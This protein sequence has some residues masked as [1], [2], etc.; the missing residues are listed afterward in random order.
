MGGKS[1]TSSQTVSIPPEVLARYNAVNSRAEQ[2][3]QKPFTSYSQDPSAFVAPLTS[4]QQAAVGN[5]NQLMG[6]Y[7]PDIST[8]QQ[9]MTAGASAAAPLV[10][11]GLGST[12]GAQQQAQG[13]YQGA[14]AGI[15][16]GTQAGQQATAQAQGYLPG[17]TQ[18]ITPMAFSQDAVQQY[19]S[20]YMSNVVAA[21]QAL[22]GQQNAQQRSQMTGDAI[23]AGAFGGDRA[24]IALAN[25]GQQQSLANQA[26]LSNLLQ[27]GYGQ[28][29]GAFQQQQGVDLSAQQANRAAQQ[30][31]A[32][33]QAA[34]GQ[35]Q[36]QQGLGA[37]Q[38]AA[39][40]GQGI[41]GMGSQT[42]AAQQQAGQN[43]FNIGQQYGQN[44]ANLGLS[45]YNAGLSGA[46]A[47]MGVG[48]VQQQTDQA[49]KSALYNQFLQQQGF[50]YQQ[51]QFLANIAEGTGSLSGSTTTTTQP[52][53]WSDKRLKDNVEK[54]GKTFDGQNIYAYNLKGDNERRL[55]LMAQE[56]EDKHPD[57][58]GLASGYKTV[59]YNKATSDAAKRGHFYS[60]G[61]VPNSEGGAVLPSMARQGFDDGGTAD[62]GD[63]NP[64]YQTL[65]SLYQS[66]LNRQA[67][68]AGL[69]YWEQQMAG[70]MTPRQ[71]QLAMDQS[72]EYQNLL[73]SQKA[74]TSGSPSTTGTTGTT[75]GSTAPA[76]YTKTI[77]D[78]YKS[79]FGRTPD[80]SG[81]QYYQNLMQQGWTADQV[82]SQLDASSEYKTAHP[83]STSTTGSTGTTD[84]S[85][86]MTLDQAKAYVGSLYSSDLNRSGD[87]S[88]VDYWAQQIADGTMSPSQVASSFAASNE[89]ALVNQT[90]LT[91]NPSSF[92]GQGLGVQPNRYGFY[93]APPTAYGSSFDPNSMI[94][95]MYGAY[96]GRTSDPSGYGYY[97]QQ[98]QSGSMSP[99]TIQSAF[100]NSAEAQGRQGYGGYQYPGAANYG[101]ASMSGYNPSSYGKG[102]QPSYSGSGY[103]A[104][105]TNYGT[106]GMP[107]ATGKGSSSYQP[108]TRY[109][110]TSGQYMPQ[111]SSGTATG[112]GPSSGS[113]SGSSSSGWNRG[114]R[115]GY[116]YGGAPDFSSLAAAQQQMYANLPGGQ[117]FE[118]IKLQPGSTRQLMT[119]TFKPQAPTSGINEAA[120]MGE[121]IAK[122]A[123][124][125][126]KAKQKLLGYTDENTG[127]KVPGLFG[128]SSE[129]AASSGQA[130]Q[131]GRPVS[132]LPG[133]TTTTT[134]KPAADLEPGLG[135]ASAPELQTAGL[136]PELTSDSDLLGGLGG[137][138]FA[139][140]GGRIGRKSGGPLNDDSSDD[141]P[142]GM[143]KTFGSG[144]NIPD[145]KGQYKLNV[146]Y[147]GSGSGS[148]SNPLGMISSGLGA[149]KAIG[150]I[151]G[152][153]MSLGAGA[154]A[155]A[156]G[157][158]GLAAAEGGGSFF[159]D[160][161][162][163]LFLARGGA[164][165]RRGYATDGGGGLNPRNPLTIDS[166]AEDVTPDDTVQLA[167]QQLAGA[168]TV[169]DDSGEHP[170]YAII[171]RGEG[172]IQK[173]KMDVDKLRIGYGSDTITKDDGTVLPVTKDTVISKE[174]A[175]RDLKRRV[176][177]FMGAAKKQVG[178]NI[179]NKLDPDSQGSLTSV[180]YN[181]GSLPSQ[182]V[183]A[184]KSGN[185]TALATAVNNLGGTN[186]GARAD[187]RAFEASLIDK[188]N[189]YAPVVSKQPAQPPSEAPSGGLAPQ[190]KF[191]TAVL[192]TQRPYASLAQ[193]AGL[194]LPEEL[195]QS[196]FW[197]PLLATVA[198]TM[199]S[200]RPKFGQALG[201]GIIGGLSAMSAQDQEQATLGLAGAKT[202]ETKQQADL[203]KAQTEGVSLQNFYKSIY[204]TGY[205]KYVFLADGTPLEFDDY[206]RRKAA[207]ERIETLGA[208]PQD[209]QKRVE[210]VIAERRKAGT[211]PPAST[212]KGS[213]P[214]IPSGPNIPAPAPDQTPAAT[215]S[216]T[217]VPSST[218][219][220]KSPTGEVPVLW[221]PKPSEPPAVPRGVGF[222]DTSVKASRDEKSRMMSPTPANETLRKSA[223][224]YA[225]STTNAAQS[226]RDVAPLH[227]ELSTII[228]DAGT[229]GGINTS[230]YGADVRANIVN[231]LNT[232]SRS[233]GATDKSGNPVTFGD[234]DQYKNIQDK[235]DTMLGSRTAASGNQ[236]SYAALER[237]RSALPNISQNPMA[238]ADLAAQNLMLNRKD[239]DRQAHLTSYLSAGGFG[240]NA[241]A[242]FDRINSDKKYADEQAVLKD[243]IAL[244][245]K[246]F[247]EMMKGKYTADDID[248]VIKK[249]YG[250]AA[251]DVT[252]YF[253]T[254]VQKPTS[255]PTTGVQ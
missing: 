206:I 20:P 222:D 199:A 171:R 7:A 60:G 136:A 219:P 83:S 28:G 74:N 8:G 168:D 237:L 13:I 121:S 246:A 157:G 35:Q 45:G 106:Q 159:A 162:P 32:Q 235:I 53:G 125:G 152:S 192:P 208:L 44:Y 238:A 250:K 72:S 170:A 130:Y 243:L 16:G 188:N 30:F 27:Q 225:A 193:K 62:T 122:L 176:P 31:G 189:V 14:L 216:P 66:E 175:E 104:A 211:L 214:P 47:Q 153:L 5:V 251:P 115:V 135:G 65:Q 19:M 172:L 239:L 24:G 11:A 80:A 96:L 241:A 138:D 155:A 149:A 119:P 70:G 156:I 18:N 85:G 21:Q 109:G 184:A 69:A 223:D 95:N 92:V 217:P 202:A 198:T 245:P 117:N 213:V 127:K 244:Q 146:G 10:Q 226:S 139:A 205:G 253:P 151:G 84:S 160:V 25:L 82:K 101:P 212:E 229:K 150:D 224:A 4:S 232:V 67:D 9:A 126:S 37:A 77:S 194:N 73:K 61:L 26:T 1:T 105:P 161:L 181:H 227:R 145:E 22:Q 247:M 129:T 200:P 93:A 51:A 88:G 49:A 33:Q 90:P 71:V 230:G 6:S 185:N 87:T 209:A 142:E 23:R 116:A 221:P 40:I 215:P 86:R 68:P 81:L 240:A 50:P 248:R 120:K 46:Q 54:V 180:A 41:Y 231:F 17:A 183:A 255:T 118:R 148:G 128:G 140:R 43:L 103:G 249:T 2:V 210:A 179:W 100:A 191:S 204:D 63:G 228:A 107:T 124:L 112:K 123:D 76:D 163:F 178:E 59:D 78:L 15:L 169:T 56:V 177:D 94:N 132:E 174:D 218:T 102:F 254:R 143:Y 3:A 197:V 201:E 196:N 79:E 64:Y 195:T 89:K 75:S 242:D 186:G 38:A 147:T 108:T 110:D 137:F 203:L 154:D 233:I 55:G 236:A 57:A 111:Q 99:Q 48:Q 220:S 97:N 207:G 113:S 114:G 131:G 34:L 158:G 12:L 173:P 144:I 91:Y 39:G 141:T 133:G 36:Y 234:L 165:N 182:I 98:L 166:T 52:S 29:L 164:A 252:R 190:G 134:T 167:R 187:R 42:G 58:V